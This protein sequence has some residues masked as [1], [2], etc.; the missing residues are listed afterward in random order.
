MFKAWIAINTH[1]DEY[2]NK[3][4]QKL[5]RSMDRVERFNSIRLYGKDILKDFDESIRLMS[6]VNILLN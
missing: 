4:R 1:A 2:Y 6:M 5:K 3:I